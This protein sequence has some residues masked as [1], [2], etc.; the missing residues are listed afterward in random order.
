MTAGWLAPLIVG[1]IV[2]LL[3]YSFVQKG[4]T[5]LKHETLVPERTK[6][7]LQQDKEWLKEKVQ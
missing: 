4:L 7:S 5:A 6:E 2:A 3:G 1:G